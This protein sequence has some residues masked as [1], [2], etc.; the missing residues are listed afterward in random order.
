MNLKRTLLLT[1]V[2][3]G[4]FLSAEAQPKRI[5]RMEM[6]GPHPAP[7]N[8]PAPPR[9][10]EAGRTDLYVADKQSPTTH[11]FVDHIQF[12]PNETAVT[13]YSDEPRD[14]SVR[15]LSST[16][17][18]CHLRGGQTLI[19]EMTGARGI[20]TSQQFRMLRAGEGF[21]V[22]FPALPEYERERIRAVDF[23]EHTPPRHRGKRDRWSYDSGKVYFNI[24]DVR[25]K[26]VQ[27]QPR[28][29]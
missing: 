17:L 24:H 19:L 22:Y 26:K 9:G 23:I 28:R 11:I 29:R 27:Y 18:Y 13:L 4:L 25:L 20:S 3:T 14:H 16:R 7:S 12:G 5:R 6:P 1:T 21:T 8:A 15:L 2:L 10:W